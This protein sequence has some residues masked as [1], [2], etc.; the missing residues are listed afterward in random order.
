[1]KKILCILQNAWG[2][3]NKCPVIFEPYPENRSAK[4]IRKAVGD[5]YFVFSNTTNEVTKTAKERAKPNYKH[6]E[7]VIKCIPLFDIVLVCGVQAKN[8]VNKYIDEI[9]KY[10][11]P[12]LFIPHPAQCLSN[13]KC[14]EI[15]HIIDSL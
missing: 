14:E 1:M 2:P 9:K 7:R 3:I 11:K 5:N 8:T 13:K 6:F 15:K 12:I 4:M 10:N